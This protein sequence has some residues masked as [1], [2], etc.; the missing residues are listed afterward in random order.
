M[1]IVHPM[2]DDDGSS[3]ILQAVPAGKFCVVEYLRGSAPKGTLLIV[4]KVNK[5]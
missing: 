3:S 4:R 2:F 1:P 5:I